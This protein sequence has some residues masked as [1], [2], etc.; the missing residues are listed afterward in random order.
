MVYIISEVGSTELLTFNKS[1]ILCFRL[2]ISVCVRASVKESKINV[3]RLP[4]C[5]PVL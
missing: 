5:L 4:L 3:G 2:S 1:H